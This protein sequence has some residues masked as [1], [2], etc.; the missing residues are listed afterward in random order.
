[1]KIIIASLLIMLSLN[2]FSQSSAKFYFDKDM[3]P[4]PKK[5]AV[6]YGTGQM[7]S[8]LYK[9]TCYYLKRK[10]PLA[11]VAHFND[12]TQRVHEGWFQY[13]YDN[14]ITGTEGNYRNGKKDGLWIHNDNNGKIN[15]SV[16]YKDGMAVARTGFYDLPA[17][18]QKLVTVDDVANNEFYTTL[19]NAHGEIISKEEIPQDYK[20][21]YFDIDTL[22]SFQGGPA[23]WTRYISKAIIK[24]VDDLSG[25]DYGTV[26]LRFVV[27]TAGNI[28][29]VKRSGHEIFQAGNDCF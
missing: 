5:K 14:G 24:H 3:H 1:M 2:G 19:Y 25:A 4:A 26:L 29:D 13:Y 7:D 12:S 15:D 11:C 6:I 9:L 28:T 10:N 27:D 16:E 8:G 20:G 21:V 22:C 18:H 23:E 17:N